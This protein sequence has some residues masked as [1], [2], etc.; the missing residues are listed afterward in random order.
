MGETT[1][2]HASHTL[3]SPS[4]SH[5]WLNC[6]G[7]VQLTKD[8]PEE[9]SSFA[10]EGTLA[11]D[12]HEA[13]LTDNAMFNFGIIS[14]EMLNAVKIS[15]SYIQNVIENRG[16][17][18]IDL[19][20]E[21]ELSLK[22]Y[23]VPGLEGGTADALLITC[24]PI[25]NKITE[26]ELIDYKHGAGI[27]VDVEGNTQLMLYALGAVLTLRLADHVRVKMTIAQPRRYHKDGIIRSCSLSARDLRR[28][29]LDVMIPMAKLAITDDAHFNPS[30]STCQWCL[31]NGN[32]D[33]QTKK[34]GGMVNSLPPVDSALNVEILKNLPDIRAFLTKLESRAHDEVLGGST[35]YP[36]FKVVNK[37]KHPKLCGDA[38]DII[39]KRYPDRI[40]QLSMRGTLKSPSELA[41]LIPPGEVSELIVKQET[42]LVVVNIDDDRKAQEILS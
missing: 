15:T 42:T 11:H 18:E 17:N 16:L 38:F 27:A 40:D 21:V 35:N 25:S 31:A 22:S 29:G 2:K 39:S 5:R 10:D 7:S 41:K 8:L 28:W 13:I 33:A 37:R 32:C 1:V 14:D 20:V 9:T 26:I 6:P 3:L 12:V 24:P 19:L 4:S 23:D 36:M 30:K 34:W